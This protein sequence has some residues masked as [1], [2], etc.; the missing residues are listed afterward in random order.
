VYAL[1][2]QGALLAE[3]KRRDGEYDEA[4]VEPGSIVS[5]A[6]FLSGTRTTACFRA[7]RRCRLLAVG[8]QQLD[9][10]LVWSRSGSFMDV[11]VWRS[12]HSSNGIRRLGLP[13]K[14]RCYVR[15]A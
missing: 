15:A 9:S 11:L 12:A 6:A 7:A 13:W 4:A 14:R 10:L 2:T 1:V 3:R 8:S 5:A